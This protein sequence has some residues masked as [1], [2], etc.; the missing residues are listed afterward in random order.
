MAMY[1]VESLNFLP[2]W[3]R[4][5][6]WTEQHIDHA[7]TTLTDLLKKNHLPHGRKPRLTDEALQQA[8]RETFQALQR[9]REA[10]EPILKEKG[11]DFI[12]FAIM[13]DYEPSFNPHKNKELVSLLNFLA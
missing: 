5:S 6:E 13:I 11:L 4:P 2:C 9:P 1:P 7:V 10:K 12:P 3:N 8:L